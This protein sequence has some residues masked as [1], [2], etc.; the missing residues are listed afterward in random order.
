[1]SDVHAEYRLES[2]AFLKDLRKRDLEFQQKLA[3]AQKPFG[4]REYL[5]LAGFA[6]VFVSAGICIGAMLASF[7]H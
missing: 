6:V 5:L 2:L 4:L 1:M 3:A 7:P